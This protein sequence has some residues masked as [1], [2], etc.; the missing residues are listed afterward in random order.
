MEA[1]K[2][3][4]RMVCMVYSVEIIATTVGNCL[5]STCVYRIITFQMV[6]SNP[7]KPVIQLRLYNALRKDKNADQVAFNVWSLVLH[8]LLLPR[9]CTGHAP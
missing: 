9:T 5:V 4:L 3:H 1:L 7:P 8:A 2:E 6:E